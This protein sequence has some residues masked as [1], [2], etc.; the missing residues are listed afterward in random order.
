MIAFGPECATST[1]EVGETSTKT[2]AFS[3]RST[4]TDSNTKQRPGLPRRLHSHA[5]RRSRSS[6]A[7][8]HA[9][10]MQLQEAPQHQE[11]QEE[12]THSLPSVHPGGRGPGSSADGRRGSPAAAVLFSAAASTAGCR[13]FRRSRRSDLVAATAAAGQSSAG[14]SDG[15]TTEARVGHTPHSRGGR[16]RASPVRRG[17]G[18]RGDRGRESFDDGR[19]AGSA[20]ATITELDVGRGLLR[21][22]LEQRTSR[23]RAISWSAGIARTNWFPANSESVDPTN[24]DCVMLGFSSG[25]GDINQYTIATVEQGR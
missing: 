3:R 14:G 6:G 13:N 19:K 18:E 22:G 8:L 12:L 24:G 9:Y 11:A 2:D 10:H 25:V 15:E 21:Q 16:A 5:D 23:P 4:S 17:C 7:R 20:A 1:G